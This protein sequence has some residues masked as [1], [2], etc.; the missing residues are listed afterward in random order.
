MRRVA[1]KLAE[2]RAI[3]VAANETK[4]EFLA[5]MSHELRTPLNA[6]IGFSDMMKQQIYGK[7]GSPFYDQ[8]TEMIH[9]SGHHLLNIINEILD[10]SKVEAGSFELNENYCDV[11]GMFAAAVKLSKAKNTDLEV[12]ITYDVPVDFPELFADP[13]IVN[14][15]LYNA[16]SNAVKFNNPGGWVDI[17]AFI[18]PENNAICLKVSDN[19]IGMTNDEIN[20]VLKPFAQVQN[21]MT[22]SHEGTGLGLPLMS[23]FMDLHGGDMDIQSEKGIG[24]TITL[25]FPNFRTAA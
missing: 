5:N 13:R 4:S 9:T 16:L 18:N 2:S 7:L 12:S 11:E 14:Q 25:T 15:I 22:R 21:P 3:A 23:A 24:T 8:Y 1:E 20:H 17:S 10:I 19:G 6:I